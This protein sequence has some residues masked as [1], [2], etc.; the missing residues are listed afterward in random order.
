MI[1]NDEVK[2]HH[3]INF[4]LSRQRAKN[5]LFSRLKLVLPRERPGRE[6]NQLPE[7]THQEEAYLAGSVSLVKE[8][9]SS[10]QAIVNQAV[11]LSAHSQP[12]VWCMSLHGQISELWYYYKAKRHVCLRDVGCGYHRPS[13]PDGTWT[14]SSVVRL[15][16][17]I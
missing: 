11:L 16:A 13:K 1:N 2:C 3:A 7:V 9:V 15:C 10:L 14:E 4:F 8:P 12:H 5:N 6:E 17:Y